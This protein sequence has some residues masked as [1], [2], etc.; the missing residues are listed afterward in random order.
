[1]ELASLRPVYEAEGPFA[2]V[3]L[4][5]RS[6]AEDAREELRLRWRALREH[7]QAEEVPDG[8]LTALDSALAAALAGEAQANGRVLVANADKVVLDAPWDAAIG[9]GDGVFWQDLPRLGPYVREYTRAIRELVVVASQTSATVR[10]EVIAEQHEP[11]ETAEQEIEG[12]AYEQVHKPRGQGESHRRIQRRAEE[13]VSQNAKDIVHRLRKIASDFRPHALVL[14][15]EVKGRQAVRAELP[16]ELDQ[17]VAETDRGGEGDKESGLALSD[18]ML[19]VAGE[20]GERKAHER[21]EQWQA[22][23]AHELAAQGAKD[24]AHAAEMGAVETLLLEPGTH[25]TR[26]EFLIK[27]GSQT[28]ATLDLVSTGTELNDGVAAILRYRMTS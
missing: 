11:R 26:E 18:E 12:S 2:T 6:P 10:Q 25:A 7:L 23:M 28:D 27:V 21:T 13:A 14:A 9:T 15:G 19:R 8:A 5:G 4:E 16:D 1:M 20:V 22:A 24:V 3:Y 17:I